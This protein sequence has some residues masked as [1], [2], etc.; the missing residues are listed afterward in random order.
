[1]TLSPRAFIVAA[2]RSAGGRRNGLISHIHPAT[3]GAAVI[4]NLVG[5]LDMDGA[6]VDDVIIGCVS[7]VGSQTA[8]IGRGVVLSSHSLPSTVP[9][10]TVDRQ[11]GSSQQA[12]HFAAQAVMSGTQDIVIAGG[13]ESMSGVPMFSAIAKGK[14]GVPNSNVMHNKY[15]A[16][17]D[18]FFSQFVSA[19]LMCSKYDITREEMDA[20]AAQSHARGLAAVQSGAFDDE[21][22]PMMGKIQKTDEAK[23][24]DKD[25]GL[26]GGTTVGA[27]AELD[28][29]V[30]LGF[31]PGTSPGG[32]A[33]F[34][35]GRITAGNAS[36]ICDGAA[37]VMV[38]NE[39]GL[40]KL[41]CEP[42]AEVR[43]LALAGTD[44]VLML[45]GP[46]P[47]TEK[48]LSNAG[49]SIQ[50]IDICEVNE[51][52]ACVPMAWQKELGADPA[53]LNMLGGAIALGHP[54]GGTGAKLMTTVVHAM[55]RDKT[56][57]YGL[58]AIC[59]GG[60]TAN[61]TIVERC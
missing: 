45:S 23:L 56:K 50:D 29:L 22:V 57:R 6:L 41:G 7:Q 52:F 33:S 1:M 5:S 16:T 31:C 43:A 27:L 60:G 53:K 34:G 8:N 19:E 61:A 32:E 28:T 42:I 38:V 11:C 39:N 20:F 36:Q 17:D 58:L 12:I 2:K 3:L 48:A 14:L 55:K 9:G 40:K 25:E 4:D 49:L 35:D 37:A 21:I 46:I 13:V 24:H 51:A 18:G 30:Q 59:E 54:L 15:G 47:A 44:P 26:R 10:T